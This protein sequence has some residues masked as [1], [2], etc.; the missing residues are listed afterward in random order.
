MRTFSM[1]KLFTIF[2][3]SVLILLVGNTADVHAQKPS[4]E[5]TGD[6]GEDR[7]YNVDDVIDTQFYAL[8]DGLPRSNQKLAIEYVGLSEVTIN[9]KEVET[10]NQGT[11]YF[12]EGTT[13]R[14]GRVTVKGKI[15]IE[16]G[17]YVKATW[18]NKQ[19]SATAEFNAE[20]HNPVL[21]VVNQPNPKSPLSVGNTF[22]QEI[23]IE[24]KVPK[25]KTLPVTAWQMDIVF[26]PTILE[27]TNVM[28]GNFLEDSESSD[29]A[30]FMP[31]IN[32]EDPE[33]VG[34]LSCAELARINLRGRINASQARYD[35]KSGV[36]L[37][38]G[39]SKTLLTIEFK[40]L[41]YAE[42]ALGLHNVRI[43]SSSDTD[44]DGTLDRV[45]YAIMI[46][47]VFVATQQPNTYEKADVNQDGMLSI[48][49]LV[50]V[51]SSIG[52]HNMRADVNDDGFVNVLDLIAIATN[53]RWQKAAAIK[54]KG[55]ASRS[56]NNPPPLAPS[57]NQNVDPTTIQSWIDLAQVE[58][59]GSEMFKRGITNL[60][61]L[62]N[63]K[64]PTKTKLLLNYP[65]PFNP[66]TWIPYQLAES[67][68]VTVT[69][70]SMNGTPIR[71]LKLG[72]QS[73]GTYIN[74]SQAAYWDG[75]NELGEP[76][77]S[78][79]Y[80]YTFTAGKFSA[81]GKMLIRK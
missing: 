19:L 26:N 38:S 40:V 36:Q 65:N 9:D 47:D 31:E 44:K 75:R 43:L 54:E 41:A 72:H 34:C 60:E 37:D 30:L 77:A 1:I 14:L 25:W 51:A 39:T 56:S 5:V 53:P 74:K 62:L 8:I 55:T 80:F 17:A 6:T 2:C 11:T 28:E 57:T 58:N 35:T 16:Q 79:V 61:A 27:V 3:L 18:T 81:T 49:D 50:I 71:T 29:D 42:E 33:A 22:T 45:S 48:L 68:N 63:S 13:D 20:D 21:I 59:D 24:N 66:E 76:S 46:K 12:A 7:F 15:I 23:T 69:I 4:F 10:T 64:V 52:T 32:L 70:Y 78:G 73:A 67:A